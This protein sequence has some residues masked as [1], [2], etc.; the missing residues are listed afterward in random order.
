MNNII[1]NRV[2]QLEIGI[3]FHMQIVWL[4]LAHLYTSNPIILNYKANAVEKLI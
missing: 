2:L 3:T 1:N 4:L